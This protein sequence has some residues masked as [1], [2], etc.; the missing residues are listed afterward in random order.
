MGPV[1]NLVFNNMRFVSDCKPNA[2]FFYV[3]SAT[4]KY[5]K[6]NLFPNI[7]QLSFEAK[8][9]VGMNHRNHPSNETI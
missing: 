8:Q 6:G 5:I 1:F 4:Y 3:M 7:F 2:I 9:K